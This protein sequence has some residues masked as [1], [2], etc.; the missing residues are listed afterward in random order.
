MPGELD[1]AVDLEDVRARVGTLHYFTAV[2]TLQ[3]ATLQL[4]NLSGI[5]PLAYVTTASETAEANK[6]M[7]GPDAWSQRVTT[8]VSI[9]FCVPAERAAGAARDELEATRRAVIRI[10]LAW[11]PKGAESPFQYRRFLLRASQDGL[12]WGEVIMRTSYH[13]RLA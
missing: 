8:D 11:T 7:G 13:L 12:I 5:P 9:L 3:E 1:F 2:E 10:L 4:E 6:L